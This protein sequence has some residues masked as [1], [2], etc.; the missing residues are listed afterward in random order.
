MSKRQPDQ[1]GAAALKRP[2]MGDDDDLID[3]EI[4]MDQEDMEQEEFVPDDAELEA[5]AAA[6]AAPSAGDTA[7]R[8]RYPRPPVPASF[9]SRSQSLGA[10]VLASVRE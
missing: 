2:R 4:E 1:P 9:D 5:P 8:F 10:C 3:D 6:A 7:P